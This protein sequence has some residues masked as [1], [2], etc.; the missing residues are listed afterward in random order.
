MGESTDENAKV[1]TEQLLRWVDLCIGPSDRH[2]RRWTLPVRFKARQL[3]TPRF[4]IILLIQTPP[5]P[6][7]T[8][9]SLMVVAGHRP[10]SARFP[11][12]L[13]ILLSDCQEY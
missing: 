3:S 6:S 12:F 5:P 8:R 2:S 1:A 13:P 4:E 10:V 9:L 7:L 11:E